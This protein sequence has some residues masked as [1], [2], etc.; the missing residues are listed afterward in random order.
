MSFYLLPE[1]IRAQ[2]LAAIQAWGEDNEGFRQSRRPIQNFINDSSIDTLAFN[3]IKGKLEDLNEVTDSLV[4]AN[5]ADIL[6][7]FKLNGAVGS[8]ELNGPEIMMR[9]IVARNAI[10]WNGDMAAHYW[11]LHSL[12]NMT[13]GSSSAIYAS[14][15]RG[16][17]SLVTINRETLRYWEEKEQDYHRI[18]GETA[19]LFTRGNELRALAAKGLN[20]IGHASQGLPSSY[21]HPGLATWRS[22]INLE[23]ERLERETE[24]YATRLQERIELGEV[25][26]TAMV[27]DPVNIATGNYIY[28]YTDLDIKG[29]SPLMFRRFYN[30]KGKEINSLGEGWSHNYEIYASEESKG[31]RVYYGEDGHSEFHEENDAG[32]YPASEYN[33]F[34]IL[35]KREDGGHLLKGLD[36]S[37]YQF[38]SKGFVESIENRHGGVTSLE[39][40]EMKLSKIYSRSGAITLTYEGERLTTATD[41]TGRQV[42]FIYKEDLLSAYIDTNGNTYSYIYDDASRL[43]KVISPERHLMVES[44]FDDYNRAIHQVFS[45]GSSMEYIYDD[46]K[47]TADFVQQDGRRITYKKDSKNQTTIITYPDGTEEEFEYHNR[48]KI[49]GWDRLENRSFSTTYDQKGNMVSTVNA[50]NVKAEFEY[51]DDNQLTRIVVD[52]EEQ[53]V[54]T[55]DDEGNLKGLVDGLQNETNFAYQQKGVVDKIILPDD[56]EIALAYDERKNITMVTDAVG[57]VTEYQYDD[58]NRVISTIDGRGNQ[59]NYQYDN[60]DNLIGV[61]NA[62]GDSQAF[63][64]SKTNKITKITDF[65]GASIKREYNNLD[66]LSKEIDQLGR[67]T[68]F[69]Y[70]KMWNMSRVIEPN[71]AETRLYYNEFN[72]LE[73]VVKADSST[74]CLEYD[75]NGNRTGIIDEAGNKTW[76]IYDALNQLIEVV[77][78]EWYRINYTYNT[79]GKITSV[80]DG[81]GN[82]V[83]YSY[84]KIGRLVKE[85]NAIGES[86]TYTYTSLGKVKTITD[87][88]ERV[89]KYDYEKG[90]RLRQIHYPDGSRETYSYDKAGNIEVYTHPTGQSQAYTYDGLNRVVKVTY[91]HGGAKSYTYDKVSNVTSMTDELGNTTTY[92]YTLT[93]KLAKVKDSLNN[94]TLYTYDESD[95][96]IEVKQLGAVALEADHELE[97]IIQK[98]REN[99]TLH[100]TRYERNQMGQVVGIVDAVGHRE[101]FFYDVKGQLIEKVDKEGYL[102]KYGYNAHGDISQIQYADGREVKMN[103]NPLRQ[104][105]EVKD[106]LGTTKIDIDPLGRAIKIIDHQDK[107]VSYEWG[108]IGEQ[109]SLT[110]P[111]GKTVKYNYDEALRLIQIDDGINPVVY[112]YDGNN[113]VVEKKFINGGKSTYSYNSLGRLQEQIN[114]DAN[115]LMDKFIYEYDLAGNPSKIIKERQNLPE[116]SG[117]YTYTYDSLHRI[118]EVVKDGNLLRAYEYDGYGN[119]V[120]LK[121][122]GKTTNYTY[123][124]LNQLIVTADAKGNEQKYIYDKRGNLTEILSNKNAT[125]GY[126]YGSFNRLEKTYNYEQD[127]GVV[128]HYNGL[129][130]RIGQAS[131]EAIKP[132]LPLMKLD[133]LDIKP[134]KQVED[135]LNLTAG[136]NNLLQRS[137]QGEVTSFV[138]DESIISA[139][140]DGSNYRSYLCDGLGSPIRILTEMGIVQESFGYDEFGNP[141]Q[142][143]SSQLNQPFTYTGYQVDRVSETYYAQAREYAPQIGRF[144]NADSYWSPDNITYGEAGGFSETPEPLIGL[145]PEQIAI[146]QSNNLYGYTMNNPLRYVDPSGLLVEGE[147]MPKWMEKIFEKAGWKGLQAGVEHLALHG[148]YRLAL[149]YNSP[150]KGRLTGLFNA[151]TRI[152][153]G[154]TVVVGWGYD[155]RRRYRDGACE[156]EAF[157]MAT[158]SAGI[159]VG[160]SVGLK[161]AGGVAGQVLIP[162]P[163]VGAA[164]GILVTAGL[165]W[166]VNLLADRFV[167]WPTEEELRERAE[168]TAEGRR[169][170]YGVVR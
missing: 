45:D 144:T 58:L 161:K 40:Q 86:R 23:R 35:T 166:G 49:A 1:D 68:R 12:D 115:S 64:Y 5:E 87:E 16:Y 91:S 24:I 156:T 26:V 95:L 76:L 41:H 44:K 34:S 71:G 8:V 65:N 107:E 73:K 129:G 63:I 121:A 163:G 70:D 4:V 143:I 37:T 141:L 27:G 142:G 59:T 114:Y 21:H 83:S 164:I 98:N 118:Q 155:I 93:G 104:L 100:V 30:S 157:T 110:Y 130:H 20:F 2:S 105:T 79:L 31:I 150:T 101:S 109:R 138:W 99:Q 77:G 117:V 139:A 69:Y 90:G 116:D 89:I 80:T 18:E 67:E 46:K 52:G 32:E 165:V 162:I 96:L 151:S 22:D 134:T 133:E 84:D 85:T 126:Y 75:V 158:V 47:G 106:W 146:I 103:Y 147:G 148:A 33:R 152:V 9:Q 7:A 60:Q 102:T 135:T 50:L 160:V 11:R 149:K 108:R 140:K 29:S 25:D 81:M 66:R 153:N 88:A 13:S 137:E 92:E 111:D 28:E 51:T 17:E 15:A 57:V 159:G 3:N 78:P 36:G 74:I 14:I 168:R 125:H 6:D 82:V 132:V 127:L 170:A 38:D 39:Y 97:S 62:V 10:T 53:G 113:R 54:L 112:N 124:A 61:K 169:E 154:V 120:S 131:G 119:R 145:I 42:K 43:S 55:Y 123:N 19:S 128:Y 48:K 122:G 72:D 167:T 56:S 94:L 136:Y